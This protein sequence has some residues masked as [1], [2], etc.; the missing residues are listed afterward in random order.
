MKSFV[1]TC[2]Q[3]KVSF[4]VATCIHVLLNFPIATNIIQ[5]QTFNASPGTGMAGEAAQVVTGIKGL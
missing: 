1:I 4:H 5:H 2:A 3:W